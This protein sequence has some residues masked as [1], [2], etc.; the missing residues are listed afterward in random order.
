[1]PQ[2][3]VV[4]SVGV[5]FGVHGPYLSGRS[6]KIPAVPPNLR[7]TLAA[8]AVEAC[9]D[10]FRAAEGRLGMPFHCVADIR[11]ESA[12][13]IDGSD[14]T[15]EEIGQWLA[16]LPVRPDHEASVI[17]AADGIGARMTFGLFVSNYD[18][19]WYS[20]MD[21]VIVLLDAGEA[22]DVLFL[23]H[24]EKITFSR[25]TAYHGAKEAGE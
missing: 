25:V 14:L 21:D 9:H 4:V 18:D 23:D 16:G 10:E 5:E 22:L 2:V 7:N 12:A 3:I 24:E 19:L 6:A 15:L 11:G 1:M 17:W 13:E 8:L 20:S